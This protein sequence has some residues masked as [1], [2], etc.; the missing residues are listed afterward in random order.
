M[1]TFIS[2]LGGQITLIKAAMSNLPVYYMSIFKMLAK[3]IKQVEKCQKDF[4]WEGRKEKNDHMVNWKDVCHPKEK[5]GL[6]VGN[7]KEMNLALMGNDDGVFQR[8]ETL[9]GVPQFLINMGS[10]KMGG[11]STHNQMLCGPRCGKI[12]VNF[13]LYSFL[14]FVSS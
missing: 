9:Y 7:I 1:E 10:T 4:L 2:F 11:I 8:R 5:G 12:Y 6:G 3:V 14:S 13:T